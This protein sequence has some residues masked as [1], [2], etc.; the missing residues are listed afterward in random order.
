MAQ[1]M[2]ASH[3]MAAARFS[4]QA[5]EVPNRRVQHVT[6]VVH[7]TTPAG[8][9]D[10]Q[11]PFAARVRAPGRPGSV[12]R[13]MAWWSGDTPRLASARGRDA[14]QYRAWNRK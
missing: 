6:A 12:S 7:P 3:Y 10:A 1:A 13:A 14:R 9:Q 5:R 4:T 8:R 2:A 11:A